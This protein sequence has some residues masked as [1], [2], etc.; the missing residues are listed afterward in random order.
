[1]I[2][3]VVHKYWAL[4]AARHDADAFVTLEAAYCEA[5]RSYHDW[6]H[7][8]DLLH[9]LDELQSLATR[10]DLVATAILWHDAV[11]STREPDGAFRP[12]AVNV[13]ASAEL[14][15]RHSRFGAADTDAVAEMILATINHVDAVASGERY[16][17]FSDDLDLFLDLDLSSLGASW[18]E[19]EENFARIRF[20]YS[21]A[22]EPL[23]YAGRLKM[24]TTFGAS[25]DRLFRR[26]ETRARWLRP[27]RENLQRSGRELTA[28][29]ERLSSVS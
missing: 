14:F 17:G 18:D 5:Q 15:R 19:F 21:W 4:V 24:V 6:R 11:Y 20:E 12:D 28:H 26:A 2:D 10:T 7:I 1:M 23:F 9:K 29:V 13:S 22:P 3:N 8:A 16:K 25:S 27:A